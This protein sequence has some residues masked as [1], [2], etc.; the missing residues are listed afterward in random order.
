MIR[1]FNSFDAVLSLLGSGAKASTKNS[2]TGSTPLHD[3][4]AFGNKE[5]VEHLLKTAKADVDAPDFKAVTALMHASGSGY[6]IICLLLLQYGAQ[7][8]ICSAEG[9]TALH[10]AATNG[11]SYVTQ[12]I[13]EAGRVL[14]FVLFLVH[15]SRDIF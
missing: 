3:A 5:I 1:R 15:V 11:D 8:D 9:M 13:V 14:A 12:Q 6:S 4:A 7:V 10:F 2:L